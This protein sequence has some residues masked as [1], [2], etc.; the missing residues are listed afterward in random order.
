MDQ[1]TAVLSP[2]T[3]IPLPSLPNLADVTQR[4]WEEL[5]D[6]LLRPKAG[7]GQ[8]VGTNVGGKGW[9]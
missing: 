4:F 6:G 2:A 9:K 3:P 1:D 8:P 7:G 5:L